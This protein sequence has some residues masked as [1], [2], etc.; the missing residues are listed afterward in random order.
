MWHQCRLSYADQD[1]QERWSLS[2]QASG[3]L[4]DETFVESY[5][6][7]ISKKKASRP[8]LFSCLLVARNQVRTSAEETRLWLGRTGNKQDQAKLDLRSHGAI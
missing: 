8:G 4:K 6:W 7:S 2:D 3:K 1:C 5:P